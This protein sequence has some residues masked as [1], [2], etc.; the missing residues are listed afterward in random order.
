[1]HDIDP[2]SEVIQDCEIIENH[3]KIERVYLITANLLAEIITG[4]QTFGGEATADTVA[5]LMQAKRN[6]TGIHT[7]RQLLLDFMAH[8]HAYTK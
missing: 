7:P 5:K 6:I 3:E 8:N 4:L 2:A 1:M